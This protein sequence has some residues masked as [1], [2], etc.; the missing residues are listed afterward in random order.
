MGYLTENLKKSD[1]AI[2]GA[3]NACIYLKN[4]ANYAKIE[5]VARK[6]KYSSKNGFKCQFLKQFM[7]DIDIKANYLKNMTLSKAEKKI[8]SGS[9]AM[10]LIHK[11]GEE[12]S[13]MIFL[14]P[15]GREIEVL[16][17]NMK[18][19]DIVLKLCQKKIKL[20]VWTVENIK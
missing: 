2:V 8:L 20:T 7:Q 13:H 18:W 9:A 10:A 5:K 6:Y 14:R 1:C 16:N 11:D 4:Q 17:Y 15:N 3:Y 12:F 19:I